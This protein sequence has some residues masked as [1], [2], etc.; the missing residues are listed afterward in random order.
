MR[1]DKGRVTDRLVDSQRFKSLPKN[2]RSFGAELKVNALLKTAGMHAFV[3][4]RQGRRMSISQKGSRGK[5]RYLKLR[6][7]VGEDGRD[8]PNC[9]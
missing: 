8:T 7:R 3:R 4:Q 2:G 1:K 6:K 9:L 5:T